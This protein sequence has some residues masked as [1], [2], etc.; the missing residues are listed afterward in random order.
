M[1]KYKNLTGGIGNL[2]DFCLKG[3]YEN[4]FEK[5]VVNHYDEFKTLLTTGESI[6]ITFNGK[7]K[8]KS[9]KMV[10]KCLF[11]KLKLKKLI[12]FMLFGNID[13]SNEHLEETF[14]IKI[15]RNPRIKEIISPEDLSSILLFNEVKEIIEKYYNNEIHLKMDNDG[16]VSH[17]FKIRLYISEKEDLFNVI[18]SYWKNENL[19]SLLIENNIQLSFLKFNKE[20]GKVKVSLSFN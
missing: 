16:N 6:V 9:L 18:Y 1:E 10:N 7:D 3:K 15:I 20:T 17:E 2:F 14:V 5:Y 11:E 8:D 12:R 13:D 19:N 4:D